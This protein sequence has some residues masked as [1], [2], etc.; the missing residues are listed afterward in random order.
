MSQVKRLADGTRN[1]GFETASAILDAIG[2]RIV[3]LGEKGQ[4]EEVAVGQDTP[5][6]VQSQLQLP[7]SYSF[8]PRLVDVNIS[9]GMSELETLKALS[10]AL[11]AKIKSLEE[12]TAGRE[13]DAAV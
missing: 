10:A 1:V 9:C 13:K 12:A 8:I 3:F 6:V 11:Q 4:Q 5:G 2:G 7:E